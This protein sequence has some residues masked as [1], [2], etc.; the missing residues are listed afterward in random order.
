MD[1]L[2]LTRVDLL[3]THQVWWNCWTRA[4]APREMPHRRQR[5]FTEVGNRV[6]QASRA[7]CITV[8][9]L[10][11]RSTCRQIIAWVGGRRGV[12]VRC[13]KSRSM[14]VQLYAG[15][16]LTMFWIQGVKKKELN[17]ESRKKGLFVFN[18]FLI[19]IFKNC[20]NYVPLRIQILFSG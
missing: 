14:R 9:H 5:Y 8:G 12:W 17:F 7:G 11:T 13:I 1:L 15:L 16:K 3:D 20:N 10:L 6:L 18:Y 2:L 4:V 19:T